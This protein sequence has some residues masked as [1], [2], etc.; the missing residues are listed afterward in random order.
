MITQWRKVVLEKFSI[1]TKSLVEEEVFRTPKVI[2][3]AIMLATSKTFFSQHLLN[4][5]GEGSM[6]VLKG[7]KLHQMMDKFVTL[8]S[9]NIQNLVA[10]FK[11]RLGNRKYVISF[12]LS[13]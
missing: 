6:E 7:K 3:L 2:V 5:D 10:S 9:P 12:S 4:E 8:F 11:H 13:K 1:K